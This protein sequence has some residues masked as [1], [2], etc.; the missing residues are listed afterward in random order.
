MP[1]RYFS[2]LTEVFQIIFKPIINHVKVLYGHF[3]PVIDVPSEMQRLDQLP[4]HRKQKI[5]S[6]KQKHRFFLFSFSIFVFNILDSIVVM[7]ADDF[8]YYNF[9]MQEL[10]YHKIFPENFWSQSDLIFFSIAI[11]SLVVYFNLWKGE[12]LDDRF[13]MYLI[14]IDEGSTENKTKT[15]IVNNKGSI[16]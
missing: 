11:C 9:R 2:I 14:G 12:W 16:F 13:N 7:A 10:F 5:E 3:D 4:D 15:L 1:S 6:D 8:D